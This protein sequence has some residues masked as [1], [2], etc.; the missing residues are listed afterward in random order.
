MESL[1]T[2]GV[3]KGGKGASRPPGKLNAKTGPPLADILIFI[4]LLFFRWFLF[5]CVFWDFFVF[6]ASSD[7][8]DIPGSLSFLHFFSECWLVAPLQGPMSPLQLSCAPLAQT[9]SYATALMIQTMARDPLF[10]SDELE[11]FLSCQSQVRVTC[12]SSHS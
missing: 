6:P 3:L 10:S 4:V 8:R 1:T 7:I 12:L 2:S 11:S 9:S 5:F